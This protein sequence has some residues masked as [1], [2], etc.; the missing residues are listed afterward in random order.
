MNGMKNEAVV[1]CSLRNGT[2]AEVLNGVNEP[3][4]STWSGYAGTLLCFIFCTA[5]PGEIRFEPIF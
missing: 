5:S 1:E 4:A 3:A 2:D